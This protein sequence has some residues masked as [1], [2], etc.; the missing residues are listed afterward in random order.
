[1]ATEVSSE[2]FN[3]WLSGLSGIATG[4]K[5]LTDC[6]QIPHLITRLSQSSN[7][8][9]QSVVSLKVFAVQHYSIN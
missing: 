3:F 5:V 6:D 1:M 7:L 8:Y 4:E 9:M 2:S